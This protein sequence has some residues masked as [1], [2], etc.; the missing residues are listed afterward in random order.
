M[1]AERKLFNNTL[2][3]Y[4]D[5]PKAGVNFIDLIPVFQNEFLFKCIVDNLA[6][7]IM[8]LLD[9]KYPNRHLYKIYG[10][11]KL[12]VADGRGLIL[13]S[14]LAYKLGF[15]MVLFRDAKKI[16]GEK[17]TVKFNNEYAEREFGIEADSIKRTD[18]IILVDDVIATGET[19]NAMRK[20]WLKAMANKDTYNYSNMFPMGI[21]AEVSLMHLK[22]LKYKSKNIITYSSRTK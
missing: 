5:F 10:E 21:I 18:A 4:K 1:M 6:N 15:D 3:I 8:K 14:A 16:P 2:K 19:M 7:R 12:M 9:S 17:V 20:C 11:P 13:G 22:Y